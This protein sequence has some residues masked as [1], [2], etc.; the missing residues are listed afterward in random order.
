[1]AGQGERGSPDGWPS[2]VPER[3]RIWDQVW[4]LLGTAAAGQGDTA[5]LDPSIDRS[6]A[7]FALWL[8]EHGRLSD[9][10]GPGGRVTG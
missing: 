9:E 5:R 7:W 1:M 6:R 3:P 8:V 10:A 2:G 4:A